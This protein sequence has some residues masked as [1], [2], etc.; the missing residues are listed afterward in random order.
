MSTPQNIK[1]WYGHQVEA[2]IVGCVLVQSALYQVSYALNLAFYIT[3][4]MFSS[5]K[6]FNSSRSTILW[7][8]VGL[9]SF[10]M[11]LQ[12]CLAIH[13]QKVRMMIS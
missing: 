10:L 2:F 7:R 11:P 3:I 8:L 13:K 4:A 1:I 12:L 9:V 5:D 6:C